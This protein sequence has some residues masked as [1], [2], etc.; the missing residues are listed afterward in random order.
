MRRH[1]CV[2][3]VVGISGSVA[4]DTV[5]V[6]L[7]GDIVERSTQRYLVTEVLNMW[8]VCMRGSHK[9]NRR[10]LHVVHSG[11]S[12]GISKQ[13]V[14]FLSRNYFHCKNPRHHIF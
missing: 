2:V 6:V 9:R 8:E 14:L 3:R 5:A 10:T 1:E 11:L 13:W 12:H 7:L 4:D